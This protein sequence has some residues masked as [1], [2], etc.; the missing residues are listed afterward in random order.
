MLCSLN[1]TGWCG[2]TTKFILGP[3]FEETTVKWPSRLIITREGFKRLSRRDHVVSIIKA[4]RPLG[5]KHNSLTHHEMSGVIRLTDMKSN[6]HI[7]VPLSTD[8]MRTGFVEIVSHSGVSGK[9]ARAGPGGTLPK[10]V[11]H[12]SSRT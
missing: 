2:F 4:N 1:V 6:S 8:P 11:D 5:K 9:T 7:S 12:F 10:K 3:H